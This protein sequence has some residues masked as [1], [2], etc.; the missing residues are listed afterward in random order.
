MMLES[1]A[2]RKIVENV[3]QRGGYARRIEDQFS[4]GFPDLIIQTSEKMPVFFVEAKI[5]TGNTFGPTPRQYVEMGRLR[6]SKYAVP[7]LA[8]W[9]N[10]VWYFIDRCEKAHVTD[11]YLSPDGMDFFDSLEEWY[12]SHSNRRM[13]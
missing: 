1:D 5:I 8:G 12:W 2:K 11:C 13:V 7:V 6:V 4:V 10:G 9:K 3:K